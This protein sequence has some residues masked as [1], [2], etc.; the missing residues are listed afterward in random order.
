MAGLCANN[1]CPSLSEIDKDSAPIFM[2]ADGQPLY[3]C[4]HQCV[5]EYELGRLVRIGKASPESLDSFRRDRR[6]WLID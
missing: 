4:S 3:F 6:A 5:Y 2:V 1:Q